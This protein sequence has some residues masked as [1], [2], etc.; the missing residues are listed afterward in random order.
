[1]CNHFGIRAILFSPCRSTIVENVSFFACKENFWQG[2]KG[3]IL[4]P[5]YSAALTDVL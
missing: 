3:E 2:D 1:M 5:I 4:R